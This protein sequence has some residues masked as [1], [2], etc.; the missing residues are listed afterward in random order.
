MKTKSS[1]VIIFI[2]FSM[3]YG[4]DDYEKWLKDQE[5]AFNTLVEEENT[6]M[7]AITKEFDD[8]QAEQERLYQNFK[9]EV[10]KNIWKLVFVMMNN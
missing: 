7:E 3:A 9:D 2:V 6:Y 8:Y 5:S 1:F 10:E 4:Q